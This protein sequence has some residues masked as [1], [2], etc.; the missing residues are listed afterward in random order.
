MK[1]SRETWERSKAELPVLEITLAQAEKALNDANELEPRVEKMEAELQT[2]ADSFSRL[3]GKVTTLLTTSSKFLRV[4][5]ALN[6]SSA[7]LQTGAT[8]KQFAQ[9]LST[10]LKAAIEDEELCQFF[11]VD[12]EILISTMASIANE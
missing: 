6:L 10:V 9:G 2:L 1:L 4:V 8:A 7:S 5:E 3:Q 12:A 11:K